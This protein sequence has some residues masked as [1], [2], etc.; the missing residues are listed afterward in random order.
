LQVKE[1]KVKFYGIFLSLVLALGIS[2]CQKSKSEAAPKAETKNQIR[3]GL[4][5]TG[6]GF[7]D[8]QFNDLTLRGVE[9]AAAE[10]G[11]AFD[12][13]SVKA[14]GDIELSLRDMASTGDYDLIICITFEALEGLRIVSKE[15]PDQKFV[16]LDTLLDAP[17]VACYMTKDEEGSFMVG[18][19][20]ALLKEE[21]FSKTD[22]LGFIGGADRSNIRIFWAGYAAGAKYINKNLTV[23]DDYVNSFADVTTAK[24]IAG[25]MIGRG[26]D[27]IFPAA[28]L[29]GNGL[30]QAAKENNTYAFG[31]NYNQ[32][33]VD[34]DHIIGSMTKNVDV[35]AYDAI[36]TVVDGT[37]K[38]SSR[39]LS[40]ADGG[41]ALVTEGSRVKIS[42]SIQKR[43]A[44]IEAKIASGEIKAPKDKESLEEFIKGL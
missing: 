13:S 16:I 44:E 3:V 19:L 40:L 42:P 38:P 1:L 17:N 23:Y 35:A 15:Y 8:G 5:S 37:F 32:N 11:I 7:G 31:V 33:S 43:L 6:A 27:I 28:G 4:V 20:A 22:K 26:A 36:K 39:V 9:R 24:E 41:V 10:L 25:A 29:S 14:V 12:K 30:F 34:P 21:G 2:G 18:A